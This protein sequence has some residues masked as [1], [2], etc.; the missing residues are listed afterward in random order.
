VPIVELRDTADPRVADYRGVRDPALAR[1]AGYFIAEGRQV[2]AEL[3]DGVRFPPRS[4]LVTPAARDALGGAL[5][6]ALAARP[7]LPVYLVPH[8]LVQDLSGFHIHQGCL[9]IGERRPDPAWQE[10]AAASRL[11]LLEAVGNPDNVGGLFRNARALGAGGVLLGPGCADPLY[12]KA[13]RTSMGAAL[14]VPFARVDDLAG[15]IAALAAAGH[16]TVAA[17]PSLRAR[18]ARA[19]AAAIGDRPVALVLGHEGDGLSAAALEACEMH[20][21]V[22]MTAGVDSINVSVAAA[23]LLYELARNG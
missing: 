17:T 18:T 6:R 11:L 3:L 19:T 1:G 4:V 15:T 14:T 22:P 2:V 20:A 23:V 21:R 5:A 12:R 10:V 16:A 8:A 7:A 13:I 9:A